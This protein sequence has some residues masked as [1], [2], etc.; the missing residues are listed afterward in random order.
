MQDYYKILG[1]SPASTGQ[2]IKKAY[3]RL[4]AKHHPDINPKGEEKF[5]QISHAYSVLSDKQQKKQYDSQRNR[6]TSAQ[7]PHSQ[8]SKTQS[9]SSSQYQQKSS[10]QSFHQKAP[11]SLDVEINLKITLEDAYFGFQKVISADIRNN[12]HIEKKQIPIKIP[13]GVREKTCLKLKNQGHCH[14]GKRGDLLAHIQLKKHSLFSLYGDNL[15]IQLPISFS[16]AVLGVQ[17]NVPTLSGSARVKIPP[18]THTGD[19]LRL[20][21]L[22]FF[23]ENGL[24]RGDLILEIHIDIPEQITQEEKKWFQHFRKNLELPPSVTKF[25]IQTR[26]YLSKK[27]G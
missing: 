23:K 5:K 13:K 10:Y 14:N 6:Q 15:V 22:G 19:L 12:G 1:I 26:K 2:A 7:Q 4:A 24:S 25:N 21:N 18:H 17:M 20:K 27:A 16:D 3:H 11:Q 8:K 9:K